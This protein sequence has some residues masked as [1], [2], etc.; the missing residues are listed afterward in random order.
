MTLRD[1]CTH[2]TPL[3]PIQRCID[4]EI[5]WEE[6]R[7]QDFKIRLK[8]AKHTL[9]LFNEEKNAGVKRQYRIKCGS[10]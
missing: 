8:R 5:G 9:K 10:L 6:W 1:K 4:C 7:I 2:G 3:Y